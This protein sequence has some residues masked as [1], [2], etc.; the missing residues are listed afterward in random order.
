M[1]I[2]LRARPAWTTLAALVV[3]LSAC[4]DVAVPSAPHDGGPVAPRT[5]LL[6]A[7]PYTD[8]AAGKNFLSCAVAAGTVTCWGPDAAKVLPIPAEVTGAARVGAGRDNACALLTDATVRCWGSN[9]RGQ[10]T[11]PAGLGAVT[12]LSVGSEFVCAIKADKT[13]TC[14]GDN[15]SGQI[16]VP[17]GLAAVA[18]IST[19]WD[20]ACAVTEGGSVECWGSNVDNQLIVP[21]DL[22][23]VL[24]VS[25]GGVHTCAVRTDGVVRCWG[26]GR[27]N[28][29]RDGYDLLA[30]PA[31]LP[32]A[33]QVA[34]GY[35]EVCALGTTGTV[36]CWGRDRAEGLHAFMA[37]LT[38]VAQIS[39]G[40]GAGCARTSNGT[41]ACFGWSQNVV[42][43]V[44]GRVNPTATF[45]ATPSSVVAG[46]SF[47]LA[48]SDA[49]VAGGSST[50]TYAFDCGSGTFGETTTNAS[51]TC[52]TTAA[53]T[54][55]V[56][57]KV[58]DQ[59]N[60][61]T[62]YSSTVEVTAAPPSSDTPLQQLTALRALVSGT[63]L[64]RPIKTALLSKLDA[65]LG[66]IDSRSVASVCGELTAFELQ[67][68][69]QRGKGIPTV[70][71]NTWIA[72]VV[73]IRVTYGCAR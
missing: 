56:R 67:V 7:A 63:T 72:H 19:G 70:T 35:E 66:G 71:A 68:T 46:A 6:D 21:S 54:R 52:A 64:T 69:A 73:A 1:K 31:D 59:D 38:N 23:P 45:T 14:W 65:A 33:A 36:R 5:L 61:H 60:D 10:S 41:A 51:T 58:I 27:Y 37:G 62:E 4:T 39:A 44:P 57:G 3:V 9:N 12:Q 17:S 16:S 15:S 22:G 11:V 48:L 34:L 13:V 42:P 49:Q 47:T 28:P 26:A 32:T 18:Q 40:E 55:S 43:A 53:G 8:V 30:V 24:H 29:G 2:M 50:F 20:H 25:A